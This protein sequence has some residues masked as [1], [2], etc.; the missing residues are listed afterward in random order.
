MFNSMKLSDLHIYAVTIASA[1]AVAFVA[2]LF[3]QRKY[4]RAKTT[5]LAKEALKTENTVVEVMSHKKNSE[6]TLHI[7]SVL[8]RIICAMLILSSMSLVITSSVINKKALDS[9]AYGNIQ[10]SQTIG[11]IMDD[12]KHGFKESKDIPSDLTGSI[13]IFYKYGCP[14]CKAI[15]DELMQELEK[16]KDNKIYF[17]STHSATGNRLVYPN[18]DTEKAF[19]NDVPAIA[20]YQYY[21]S[22]QPNAKKSILYTFDADKNPILD[23]LV[24]ETIIRCQNESSTNITE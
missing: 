21:D 23:K 20:Y 15:H 16:Y 11:E 22:S 14:D 18:G 3:V 2:M 19:I 10:Y 7:A 6:K 8:L 9:G 24:L 4:M 5:R 13:V 1:A 12:V 17:V